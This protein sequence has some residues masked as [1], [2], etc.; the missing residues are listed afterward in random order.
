MSSP[1]SLS[2]IVPALPT[3]R[4]RSWFRRFAAVAWAVSALAALSLWL[5][6][7]SG[8][9]HTIAWLW[10]PPA[11]VGLL[12]AL[13]AL[14]GGSAGVLLG[15]RR[16]AMFAWLIVGVVPLL[17]AAGL[18]A[19]MLVDQGRRNLPDTFAHKVGRMAA[20]TL[21]ELHAG[22]S[23]PHRLE[24]ANLVMYYDGRV[25]D[26]EGDAAAMDAHLAPQEEI[27]G[28]RQL[29]QIRWVRG[30]ALDMQAMCIHSTALGSASSPAS[31]LD[32][33]ELAHAFI[34]QFSDRASEPPMLLLEGWA[35]AVDRHAEPL[36]Q[37][38]LVARQQLAVWR[39]TSAPL[40]SLSSPDL[41]HV[42]IAHAYECGGA[43]VDFL[44]RRY[45]P[46]K[47]LNFY[48]AIHPDSCEAECERIFGCSWDNLEQRFWADV[49]KS[50]ERSKRSR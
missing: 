43:F 27:L 44:L 10:V 24:T 38:A 4:T 22:L 1:T 31:H 14:L 29:F 23:Y 39:K 25:T 21:F 6:Y 37:T 33:H 13:A 15:S 35:M 12:A 49:G 30:A 7:Q 17:L 28:R 5:Q 50:L 18:V 16:G 45:G 41:Y 3:R 19:Y 40:H 2:P 8:V 46:A 42:G 32:R 36:A 20:V 9:Y 47:F 48:N 11:A 34:Y 26:P